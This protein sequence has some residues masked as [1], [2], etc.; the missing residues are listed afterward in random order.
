MVLKYD[1]GI[2]GSGPAG[3][4]AALSYRK[5]GLSVVLFEKNEVGGVCLNRGCIPTKAILHSADFY[6]ELKGVDDIGISVGDVVLDFQK[7]MTKKNL[8]VERLR[9]GLELTLKNRGVDVIK[10]EAKIIDK[11]TI[12]AD[13][14]TYNCSKVVAATGSIPRSFKGMEFDHKYILSSDDVLELTEL[15]KSILIVGSG[16]IGVEWARIFSEFGSEVTVVE[17]ADNLLP[18]ADIEVSKR[19][20]R[21]FKSKKIKIYKSVSVEKI[22]KNENC[23]MHLSNGEVVE[24]DKVLLAAGRTVPNADKIDGVTYLGDVCGEM[25]L[26]HF[27]SKQAIEA[28]E[29]IPFDKTLVP[30][31]V[32]GSPEIAWV[33]K[34]EQDLEAGTYQKSSILI[35]ALGKSHCDNSTEGFIKVLAQD[36]KIVGAHIVSKE[37]ASLI[38]EIVIAMQNNVTVDKLKEVCFAHPTYSE[39]IFETLF[40]LQ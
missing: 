25:M 5:K 1:I 11:N 21:I 22:E 3:Y 36:N 31:V 17:L 6:E 12:E 13:N 33:G 40:G 16:A 29:G 23:T 24:A 28:A 35:S 30:S 38:Q 18:I 2:V 39:G 14:K 27:A 10:S 15:P 37:A 34:R 20:E 4:T 26:A 8:V 32:Y 7:V 19:I 9:R